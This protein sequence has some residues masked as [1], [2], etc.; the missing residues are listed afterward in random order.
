[1]LAYVEDLVTVAKSEEQMS[2]I[3][4]RF[5]YIDRKKLVL[6]QI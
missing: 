5:K 4:E 3:V 1:M 2:P 6:E